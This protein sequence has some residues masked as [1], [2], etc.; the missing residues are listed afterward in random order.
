MKFYGDDFNKYYDKCTN[1]FTYT[2]RTAEGFYI[3]HEPEK[4]NNWIRLR[5][6]LMFSFNN[7][8]RSTDKLYIPLIIINTFKLNSIKCYI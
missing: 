5:N 7:L 6:K 2:L 3:P 4:I 1:K 8:E